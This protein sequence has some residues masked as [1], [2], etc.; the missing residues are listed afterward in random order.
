[1]SEY[2]D[3]MNRARDAMAASGVHA[4]C[5]SVG[6]DL[7]YLTGYSA[8]P[9]ERLTMLV[10]PA[11]GEAV[12]VVPGLEAPR[13]DSSGGEFAI[14]G[15][16]ETEDPIEIVND[17]LGGAST[18]AIG[19]ETWTS[20]TLDLQ[21]TSERSWIEAGGLMQSLRIIK[22]EDEID[23]L[24]VAGASVDAVVE[25]MSNVRFSGRTEAN[26]AKEFTDRLIAAGHEA[27]DFAIVA[28]GTNGASP[29]HHPEQRVIEQGD[30]VVCDF[31]GFQNGYGSDTTRMFVVGKAPEGFDEAYAVLR[32]AQ[33][34]AVQF[35]RP[36]VTAESVDAAARSIIADA[37][38]GD[39][40]I[41]RI[42]H[43]IGMDTHEHPYLVEGNSEVIE[44]GMAFSIEP[45]IYIPGRWGMR[46]EDIV[47]V[48]ETGAERLNNSSHDYRVVG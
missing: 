32:E 33:E 12:L 26:V 43:G 28:S 11:E 15:W 41:H 42:G 46:L 45:G 48:S 21:E 9:L 17:L 10:L 29:H 4:L 27:V 7:P 35:V 47:V 16:G 1:M 23:K 8:M 18:V 6:K 22:T 13:V 39:Y 3:R 30:A 5:L 20:F 40:F 2:L 19:N 31:G 25:Q 14:R 34:A 38:F 36:G 44:A 37:G 24:R